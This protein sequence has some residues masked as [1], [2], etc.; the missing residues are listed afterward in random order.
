MLRQL[1][2]ALDVNRAITIRG[3]DVL[4]VGVYREGEDSAGEVDAAVFA[5]MLPFLDGDAA[6]I[7]SC[8]ELAIQRDDCLA[9]VLFR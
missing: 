1:R 5:L 3:G 2:H 6:H 7:G 8:N 4:A 9:R